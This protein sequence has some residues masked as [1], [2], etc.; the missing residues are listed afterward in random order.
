MQPATAV[1]WQLEKWMQHWFNA[2]TLWESKQKR[3][4]VR[5]RCPF[6]ELSN[7]VPQHLL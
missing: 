7:G 1:R 2:I 3:Y 5:I 6:H 4:A